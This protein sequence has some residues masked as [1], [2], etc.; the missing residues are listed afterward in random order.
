MTWCNCTK[1]IAHK[2]I[3]LTDPGSKRFAVFVNANEHQHDKTQS[4]GCLM[5]GQTAADWILTKAKTLEQ[6]IVE[7]KG[8]DVDHA[9]MQIIATAEYL[10]EQGKLGT[11]VAGL[12]VCTE[13]PRNN[14]K[15]QRARVQFARNFKG[16]IHAV[17]KSKEFTLAQV[18][19]FDGPT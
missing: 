14:T 3:K 4:D 9:C 13:Y 16:P 2:K 6:V 11:T 18:I 8:K 12:I 19:R 10:R 17:T 5:V 7:L 15:I 1:S